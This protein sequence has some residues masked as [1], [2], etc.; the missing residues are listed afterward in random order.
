MYMP[1][2][3]GL[4]SQLDS[5][6]GDNFLV[7]LAEYLEEFSVGLLAVASKMRYRVIQRKRRREADSSPAPR[8]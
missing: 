6:M 5:A 7:F 2:V 8:D 3:L 4:I 1:C